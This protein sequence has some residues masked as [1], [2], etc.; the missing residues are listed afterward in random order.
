MVKV[1]HFMDESDIGSGEKTPAQLEDL[2]QTSHLQEQLESAQREA[3]PQDGSRLYQVVE[4]QQYLFEHEGHAAQP[5]EELD[6][7]ADEPDAAGMAQGAAGTRAD[8]AVDPKQGG[9]P[10]AGR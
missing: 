6:R 5:S 8:I 4:E 3:T 2:E 1:K 10:Q 9:R 7:N